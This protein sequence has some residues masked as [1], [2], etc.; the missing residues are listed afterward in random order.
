MMEESLLNFA[1][2]FA[3]ELEVENVEEWQRYDRFLIAGMGGSALAAQLFS[4][5][6][7]ELDLI[8]HR[9]YGL[10][11]LPSE[12]W[13]NRL[14]IASSYSGNTE[15]T[16]SAFEE[17]RMKHMRVAAISTGGKLLEIAKPQDIPFIRFPDL[18]LRPRLAV[19]LSF[20]GFC[21]LMGDEELYEKTKQL[22]FE[23]RPKELQEQG[24]RLAQE[25]A[26]KI[27]VI[28]GS[29]YTFPIAYQWK[30]A[31][32]ET[33]RIPAFANA[34]PELNH[35]EMAGFDITQGTKELG[36][37]VH[38]I[39]LK[40]NG[41]LEQ[42]KKRMEVAQQMWKAKGLQVSEVRLE[43]HS[44]VLQAFSGILLGHFTALALAQQYGTAS[45]KDEMIE[46][47]KKRIG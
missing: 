25:L 6:R 38:V 22:A 43:G 41:D 44:E 23:L 39:L 2:Q 10:P 24:N 45:E 4:S 26:G 9:D 31:F 13:R 33:A 36:G 3:Q 12:R 42:V 27:P 11:V 40:R 32:N 29:G 8:V 18:H 19:G 35:N 34:F 7:P 1:Q 15:E 5:F 21:K 14:V 16:L 47:F 46:E 28:Y 30:I 20:L 37:K 17:A